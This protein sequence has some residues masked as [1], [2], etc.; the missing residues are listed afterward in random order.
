MAVW[1]LSPVPT[2]RTRSVPVSPSAATILAIRLGWVVICPCGIPDRLVQIRP[3]G[4]LAGHEPGPGHLAEGVQDP[5]V[6]DPLGPQDP[7]QVLR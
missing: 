5:A 6:P 4:G 3:A 2:S 7:D 1:N